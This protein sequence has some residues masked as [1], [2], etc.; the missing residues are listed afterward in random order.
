MKISEVKCKQ[1]LSH[2]GIKDFSYSMNPYVGCPHNC[3]YCY[4]RFML[5]FKPKG[6]KWGEFVD[7][8]I[9]FPEALQ[10]QIGTLKPGKVMISS[11]TDAYLPLEKKY[12][13]TRKSLEI[14]ARYKFSISLLTKSDLVLRDVDVLKKFGEDS[15]VGF[16]ICFN[17]DEDRKNFEPHSSPI[18]NRFSALKELKKANIKTFA[19][20]GPFIPGV[21]DKNLEELFKRFAD[22]GISCLLFDNS[23]SL[24]V[25][26]QLANR[27][28]EG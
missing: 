11:V 28:F 3:V 12:E 15:E 13:I 14:L 26:R 7:V 4:A 18:G 23:N 21:S 6:T 5:R 22:A 19:F 8:K 17:N 27:E 10:K 20:L 25:L 9:N 16:T 2:C 24:L 1:A